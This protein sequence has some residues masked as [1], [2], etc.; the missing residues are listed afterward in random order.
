MRRPDTRYEDIGPDYF[1][2][3]CGGEVLSCEQAARDYGYSAVETF[4]RRDSA[5][6]PSGPLDLY[7]CAGFSI[8]RDDKEYPLVRRGVEVV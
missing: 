2:G 8:L 7:L 4:A 6:N 5:N 3:L 1:A